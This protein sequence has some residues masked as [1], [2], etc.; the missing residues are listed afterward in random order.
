MER[1]TF[2]AGCFWGV[3]LLFSK[4]EGVESTR[5]GYIGGETEDPTYKEVCSDETGHAEAIEISFDPNK[6][7]YEELLDIFWGQPQP[8]YLK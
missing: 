2:A 8:Y 6:V 1:A 3:E 7:S 4:I 5:V